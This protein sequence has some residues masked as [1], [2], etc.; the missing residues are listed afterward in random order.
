MGRRGEQWLR[1]RERESGSE[2]EEFSYFRQWGDSFTGKFSVFH[3]FRISRDYQRQPSPS[4][5]PPALYHRT[6]VPPLLSFF[7][8]ALLFWEF[9]FCSRGSLETSEKRNVTYFGRLETTMRKNDRPRLFLPPITF[10]A[11]TNELPS[12]P[13]SNTRM[14]FSEYPSEPINICMYVRT[15]VCIGSGGR[16]RKRSVFSLGSTTRDVT[17][18]SPP[19][20]FTLPFPSF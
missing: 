20:H 3:V 7:L 19:S 9:F 15:Y 14:L 6:F 8:F 10:G 1:E 13:T 16:R 2:E 4:F 18:N 11:R 17:Q 5:S 12:K